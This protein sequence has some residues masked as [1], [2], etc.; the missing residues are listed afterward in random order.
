[1]VVDHECV[2]FADDTSVIIRCDNEKNYKEEIHKLLKEI[3]EWL[4]INAL[5]INLDKTKIINFRSHKSKSKQLDITC[6]NTPI[7]QVKN[8][9]F[10]GITV[11]EH[12]I[13][14]DHIDNICTKNNK[15]VFAIKRIK[16][17]SSK[18]TS[19][20]VY[21]AYVCSMITG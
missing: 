5:K 16:D 17:S 8:I 9:K 13:W 12:L 7:E 2:L 14:K 19:L 18:H 6:N 1:M 11:N 4:D 20:M 10:L 15:S 3:T 21:H